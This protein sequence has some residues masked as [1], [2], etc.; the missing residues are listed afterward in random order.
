ML[1]LIVFA[2][3]AG[4]ATAV[5]PCVLPVL[6]VLL[7]ASAV[8]GRRRPI[9]IVTGLAVTFTITIAGL[10]SVIDGVGVA[11][12]AARKIAIAV[13]LAAGLALLV[14]ALGDRIEA[15][16]SRLARF[17]P[18]SRGT[19]FGSGL[20]VGAALGFLYAPCAGPILAAVVSVG[21]SQGSSAKIIALAASYSA[22]SAAV[23]LV[24]AL[25]GRRLTERL[26]SA[27]RGPALQRAVGAVLVATAVVMAA[28]LDVRFQTALARH[29]P[30]FIVNPTKS[31]ESSD[32]VEQRLADIRGRPRFDSSGAPVTI[33]ARRSSKGVRSSLPSLGPAPDF[34]GNQRWFNTPGGRPLTLRGLRGKVVLIDFWTYTCINCIRTLPYVEAWYQRYKHDGL[35]V[36]GVHTPEFAFEKDAGNVAA[37]IHQN[38]LRYPVAQDNDYGTWNAW[39]NQFWPAH[40]LIDARGQVRYTHFGEGDYGK[41]ESAIRSLLG[42]ANGAPLGQRVRAHVEVPSAT[43]QT[44]ETYLGAARSE[45][46][47]PSAVTSGTRRYRPL[48]GRL[49]LNHLTLGGTWSI[50]DEAATARSGATLKLRFAARRVFLVLGSAGGAPR[51]L[52]VGLDGHPVSRGSA[53]A[54]VHAGAATVQGQRLYRLVN[55]PRVEQHELEL[56]FAPGISAYAFT[57]G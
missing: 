3:I 2:A 26:R 16:L 31:L 6:P 48:G 28:N 18:R 40:Y 52:Q 49:P 29:F 45:R 53:G 1:L 27:A 55:L 14:P 30:S 39:S 56:H 43:L 32:A 19:G 34:T 35:V 7:S 54:D 20:V 51:R 38:G 37:A 5:T 10:A 42:E 15:P 11:D 23:L 24:L 4:A 33:A 22:G 9:G 12:G 50:G 36:V 8:G 47:L 44:P 25:G 13:L 17:G 41:T 46:M 21:V 57:F